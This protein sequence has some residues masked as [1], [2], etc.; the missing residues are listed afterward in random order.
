MKIVAKSKLESDADEIFRAALVPS[1]GQ[2]FI[3]STKNLY[4]IGRQASSVRS[5]A[6]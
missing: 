5:A 3:R 4:C 2:I 1:Q 6:K